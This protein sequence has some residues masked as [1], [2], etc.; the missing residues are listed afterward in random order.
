MDT[1]FSEQ[2][3]RQEAIRRR[4]MGATR[5]EICRAL[6]RSPRWFDKWWQEYQ[7]SP[8]TDFADHAR[9]PHTSPHQTPRSVEEA[10]ITIRSVLEAAA[11]PETKYG[12]IGAAS[13]R[14]ELERLHIQPVP[15]HPTIQRIL[16]RHGVTHPVGAGNAA[17]YYPWPIAWAVNAIHATDIITRHV[18][19][20]EE[21]QNFHTLDHFSQ[22]VSL[23]QA[24]AKSSPIMCV[25]LRKSWAKLGRPF[26]HQ[27]DNEATFCGGHTHPRVI[28]QVVRLCLFCGIEP[29]FTP[30]YDPKRNY[31][32]ETFHSVWVRSFWARERFRNLAHVQAE[33]STFER[34]Y[35]TRYRPPS[36]ENQTPAQVRRGCPVWRLTPALQRLI[37]TSRLPI[38]AGRIHFMRKVT[39]TG[40]IT[41]LNE[42]W[43]LGEKWIGE[44]VRATIHT[45]E[46]T[47]TFW[48]KADAETDWQLIKSRQ[49]RLKES[50]HELLPVF[51]RNS[52]RCRDCLPG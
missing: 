5:C 39:Q 19:G 37:P 46:Q 3:L 35:H 14:S 9:A 41:L 45:A 33:I 13:I 1:I 30:Y 52:A 6:G 21:I 28:G 40:D 38:T 31:Q 22:A 20:G 4:L 8:L 44:Y 36:L 12:L 25:H 42:T 7:R 49:Y 24:A 27:L 50:I 2:A 26:I 43:P 17:A 18:Q 15:S 23:T 51:R 11:T 47:L 48:Y 32:I 29:L 34:W 16:V 10:I